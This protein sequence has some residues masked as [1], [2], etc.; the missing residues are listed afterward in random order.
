[1]LKKTKDSRIIYTSSILAHLNDLTTKSFS[2]DHKLHVLYGFFLYGNSKA[3]ILMATKIFGQKLK[4]YDIKVYAVN[5]GMT[6]TP[7]QEKVYDNALKIQS[8]IRLLPR[9]IY[10]WYN[11][12]FSQVIV[13][14]C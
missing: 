7:M 14:F 8:L 6:S 1:M 12:L 10:N 5:P 3:L 11:N 4:K 13:Y 2:E 9:T